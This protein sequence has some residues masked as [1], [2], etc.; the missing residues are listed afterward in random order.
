MKPGNQLAGILLGV[1]VANRGRASGP[2]WQVTAADAGHPLPPSLRDRAVRNQ[3][4][5]PPLAVAALLSRLG[6]RQRL[7]FGFGHG[8]VQLVRN[9]PQR[10]CGLERPV[11]IK[12]F[13]AIASQDL[14]QALQNAAFFLTFRC[15]DGELSLWNGQSAQP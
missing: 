6:Q 13:G 4:A 8:R 5:Q 3:L 12:Q 2:A 10:R 7:G 15:S 1:V 14:E 9:R 11:S